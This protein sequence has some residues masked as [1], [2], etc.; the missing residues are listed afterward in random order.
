MDGARRGAARSD[1]LVLFGVT[2]VDPV[3]VKHRRA[4]P[5]ERG[6]G[7]PLEAG[8]L[9]ARDHGREN[10]GLADVARD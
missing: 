8:P 10:L 6:S 4:S 3:L 1:A 7:R 9:V 2:A 5:Y